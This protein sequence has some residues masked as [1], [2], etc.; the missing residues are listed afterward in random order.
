MNSFI[1]VYHSTANRQFSLDN[2]NAL[3]IPK[4]YKVYAKC[5]HELMKLILTFMYFSSYDQ[6]T[7]RRGQDVTLLIKS[8]APTIS[9]IE[10]LEL[11]SSKTKIRQHYSSIVNSYFYNR[12]EVG[13]IEFFSKCKIY[14]TKVYYR[15][16]CM[17]YIIIIFRFSY[18]GFLEKFL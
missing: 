18:K 7:A 9:S 15:I 6:A 17:M 10:M 14:V 2:F 1:S 11:N 8:F 5:I 3:I 12:N 16:G 4:R 13:V